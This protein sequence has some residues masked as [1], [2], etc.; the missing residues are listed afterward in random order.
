MKKVIPMFM[1]AMLLVMPTAQISAE[2]AKNPVQEKAQKLASVLLSDY[3][4]TGVQ[5][6]IMDSGSIVLSGGAGVSNKAAGS[7][8][9][10]DTMFGMGS[11]GKVYSTAAVMMLVD[12]G[13]VDIDQPY[14]KYV[15]N[16][17]MADKRYKD[18][19]VRM[20]MNHSSGIY[21]SHYAN[22]IL[23]ADNDTWAHDKLLQRMQSETLKS[24]P[25][26]YSVYAN[27]G[28]Q[29]LEI[30][31]E[32]V[33]GL[34]YSK[35]IEQ[36]LS[37]P[38]QL[39]S[40]KSPLDTFDRERLAKT[41]HPS[42]N[43][44]LPVENANL[45]GS[46]GL[47]GTTEEMTKFGEVLMGDCPSVLSKKSAEAMQKPEYRNGIWVP[48]ET[49][50]INF[51]LGWDSVS[52][53]PFDQYGIK[54]LTKG[55]DTTMYHAALTSLPEHHISI[56][57]LTSGGS[58]GFNTNFASNVLLEYL[59]EKGAIK[60]LLPDRVF[61]TPVKVDMPTDQLKF[62][63][64]YGTVGGTLDISIKNGEIKLPTLLGGM[65]PDQTYVYTKDGQ[66]K[67][68]EGNIA[69]SFDRQSNGKTYLKVNATLDLAGIGREFMV[70]YEYQ[71][72]AANPL[73]HAVK[74]AW[75]KRNGKTF[76]ALDEKI[77]SIFY[78]TPQVLNKKVKLD[79]RNGYAS[80][81]K[82]IDKNKAVNVTEIPGTAGRDTFDLNFHTV[83]GNE[84][85][86]IDGM[87]YISEDAVHPM[88]SGDSSTT[89]IHEDGKARW[90]KIDRKTANKTM[91]VE[92]PTNGG[93]NVY[94]KT[95][96]TIGSSIITGEKSVVLPE[97]GLIVFGGKAGDV[98]K[99][100]I[101]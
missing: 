92:V 46:G 85:L 88:N 86:A 5:Y 52:L 34:S 93:F 70:N 72:L 50:N 14:Y 51:G 12:D 26:E 25:G 73:K 101:K 13:K 22:A 96:T 41:Y 38:L 76:Y 7:P 65:I 33:S 29:L 89:I 90:F 87:S 61:E 55:G 94:D 27:D 30:L 45:I 40:T 78:L 24:T 19:T 68:K 23:F 36:R 77:T 59:K 48:E 42:F 99:I 82:I 80:G 91:T 31:V 57:V 64:L 49:N 9:T 75:E 11:V 63:G 43:Q 47:Y 66:F 84:Y 44:A 21:G 54:A 1:T 6:A 35:F 67:N 62:A 69:I 18:I 17:R 74:T 53:A 16:F 20:L 83:R 4:V 39:I 15:K 60:K 71:K 100:K 3:G 28:F 58:S 56:A 10:K 37:K 79:V 2:T 98:F 8:V 97:G 95:G 32:H 81:T